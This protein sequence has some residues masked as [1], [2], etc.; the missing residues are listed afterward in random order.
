MLGRPPNNKRKIPVPLSASLQVIE[1]IQ[2][3][4]QSSSP[5]PG[6][7]EV[8]GTRNVRY[9]QIE[10]D[11]SFNCLYPSLHS[12]LRKPSPVT[13]SLLMYRYR[14]TFRCHVGHSIP[15]R[16]LSRPSSSSTR[17][18]FLL[19]TLFQNVGRLPV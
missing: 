17:T 11:F 9:I 19:S 4:D 8:L 18:L 3:I 5:T 16:S 2:R 1:R 14:N 7:D 13:V 15:P 12:L 6:W 10:C